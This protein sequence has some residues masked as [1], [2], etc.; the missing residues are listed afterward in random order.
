M[1][2]QRPVV[3]THPG[4]ASQWLPVAHRVMLGLAGGR[5]LCAWPLG[6]TWPC[7]E[8]LEVA[9]PGPRAGPGPLGEALC[10]TQELP[11]LGKGLC[12]LLL[13][14]QEQVA[15]DVYCPWLAQGIPG[16]Q[17]CS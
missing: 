9:W 3:L 17:M 7:A 8:V 14:E 6:S 1:S 2:Q 16:A 12:F 15:V 10:P 13:T 5:G 11:L 4:H